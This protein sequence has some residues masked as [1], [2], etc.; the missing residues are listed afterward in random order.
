ML[1]FRRS[2]LMISDIIIINLAIFLSFI[3]QY[4]GMYSPYSDKVQI[5][6]H[7]V[8]T[9]TSLM[10]YLL[11]DL[12]SSLWKYASLDEM[13]W[14]VFSCCFSILISSVI[15]YFHGIHLTAS[16]Y[17]NMAFINVFLLGAIRISYR[18]ARRIRIL[19]RLNGMKEYRKVMIIGAG[20]AGAMV[21]RELQRHPEMGLKPV[22]IIDDDPLKRHSS[23]SGIPIRGSRESI[24]KIV[25]DKEIDEIIVAIPSA[26]RSEIREILNECKKTRCKLKILPG[27]YELIDGK[28]TTQQIRDVQIEDLLG[29]DPIQ[30][31]LCEIAGY[32][33][34]EVVLVTGGGGSIGSELCRQIARFHPRLLLILDIYENNAYT[35]QQELLR[36][37]PRSAA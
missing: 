13:F 3:I 1:L 15:L 17:V 24:V 8:I 26:P 18:V 19:F 16:H 4:E 22:V 30:V 7:L 2:L 29:R 31:D 32:L 5:I 35:L 33:E 11:F 12:Y 27:V 34:G 9:L 20:E 37:Y 23:L 28:V 10:V 36:S 21:I 14:I 6:I 25:E